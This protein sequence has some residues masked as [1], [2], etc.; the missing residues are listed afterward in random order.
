MLPAGRAD[1]VAG[2][3]LPLPVTVISE[4]LGVPAGDRAGFQEWTDAMLAQHPDRFDKDV[5]DDAW[6]RM[7]A[8]LEGCSRPSG[9][10]RRRPAERADHRARRGGE[11][12]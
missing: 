6:R 10:A 12:G 7:W 2:F 11:P 1:L 5:M 9:P 3:A 4:L 8:Y